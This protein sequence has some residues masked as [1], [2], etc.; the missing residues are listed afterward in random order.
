VL[1]LRPGEPTTEVRPTVVGNAGH[2][3]A[4]TRIAHRLRD[5][6]AVHQRKTHGSRQRRPLAGGNSNRGSPQGHA[7]RPPEEDPRQ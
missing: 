1:P 5:T 7:S 2:W 6:Q 4:V 3:P